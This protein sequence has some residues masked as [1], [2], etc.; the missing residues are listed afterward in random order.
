M[1]PPQQDRLFFFFSL[2]LL[3]ADVNVLVIGKK[4]RRGTSHVSGP[5]GPPYTLEVVKEVFMGGCGLIRAQERLDIYGV[6]EGGGLGTGGGLSASAD[7]ECLVCMTNP[8]EVMLY[9]CRSVSYP[10][11]Q[12]RDLHRR[13][14]ERRLH[15]PGQ[16]SLWTPRLLLSGGER[17]L[18][19]RVYIHGSVD[20]CMSVGFYV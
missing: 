9:P 13:T 11:Q 20:L 18:R 5:S 8:K 10:P 14:I 2:L 6:D 1:V 3:Q 15:T 7:K 16:T 19:T 17:F 12:Q 4:Q